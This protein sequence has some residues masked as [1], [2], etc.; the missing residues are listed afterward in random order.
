LLGGFKGRLAA[1]NENTDSENEEDNEVI[2]RER[3]SETRDFSQRASHNSSRPNFCDVTQ[4]HDLN[5]ATQR[6]LIEG[7]PPSAKRARFFF[8]RC[9]DATFNPSKISGAE[10][11]LAPDSDEDK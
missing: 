2:T 7:T 8:Q 5:N 10:K 11:I 9:F 4:P 3:I 6:E 1:Y